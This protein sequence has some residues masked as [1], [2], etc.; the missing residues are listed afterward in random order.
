[1]HK[2][3]FERSD[4]YQLTCWN[5]CSSFTEMFGYVNL[6]IIEL[7]MMNFHV[8]DIYIYIYIYIY[9][10]TW[11]IMTCCCWIVIVYMI[12]SCGCCWLLLIIS[13][14]GLGMNY[15]WSCCCRIQLLRRI[16]F[17]LLFKLV[18]LKNGFK[19]IYK[20]YSIVVKQVCSM[21]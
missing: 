5:S 10:D 7:L 3:L 9:M 15:D 19:I 11:W 21:C 1:M 4:L 14:H 16:E 17:W 20:T 2:C 18:V 12:I 13:Y 6:L 8:H